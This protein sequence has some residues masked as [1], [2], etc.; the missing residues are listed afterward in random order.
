MFH[1]TK[2][3]LA[4]AIK[5]NDGYCPCQFE[6]TEDTKCPC[7][8]YRENGTCECGLY[9][10]KLHFEKVS[11]AE[12]FSS[13]KQYMNMSEESAWEEYKNII[14]PRR[15]TSRSMCYDFAAPYEVSIE[16]GVVTTIPTGIRAIM[17]GN[18]GLLIFPRS[19]LG[20]KRGLRVRGTVA[21]IDADYYTADNEGNI[22][23]NVTADMPIHLMP[24]ERFC[25]G[26][27]MKYETTFDDNPISNERTGGF[28][29][30][31]KT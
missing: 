8:N 7:K 18:M 24:G 19:G 5:E 1:G 25:Q 22:I 11:F 31:G 6:R 21:A 13:V 28:G 15:G 26:V 20:N 9:E 30:T 3:E 2:A 14:L 29:S 10:P 12:F 23:L 17:P 4:A 16:P 27:F